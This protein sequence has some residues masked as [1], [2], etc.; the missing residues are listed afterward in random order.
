MTKQTKRSK[1]AAEV[2]TPGKI[3]S[4]EEAV[5]LLAQLS[6]TTKFTE[7]VDM[8]L[9]L[10]INAKKS[11]Q[12]VRGSAL[13]PHGTGKS[14]KVAVFT[15]GDNA[16]KAKAAGADIV[17][18]EDLAAKIKQGE[19]DFDVLIASPD[20]MREVGKL[21]QILGPKGLMPNPKVGTVTPNV[22]KAVAEA[23]A[24][25]ANFRN[26]KNGIIHCSIG[27]IDFD[28]TKLGSNM[29][30]VLAEVKKLKPAN[31]RGKYFKKLTLATTMGPGL[32]VELP[33]EL[34]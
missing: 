14:V 31:A 3:Y 10:G 6:Q 11:D 24:G 28:V 2:V 4:V 5:S 25:K 15:Q 16:D 1:R 26:D 23:K 8:S 30:A 32:Q 13:L 18:F 19:M 29:S 34:V 33:E 27:K 21:G 9:N 12:S 17:G 20:A 7:T 22:A